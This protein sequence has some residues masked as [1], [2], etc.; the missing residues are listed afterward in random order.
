MQKG[1]SFE[2]TNMQLMAEVI[3]MCALEINFSLSMTTL[4]T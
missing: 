3:F 1:I 4:A 2:K